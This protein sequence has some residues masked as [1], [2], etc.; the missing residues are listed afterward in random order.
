MNAAA[1][2]FAGEIRRMETEEVKR[3]NF[4]Q[5]LAYAVYETRTILADMRFAEV[6]EC[7]ESMPEGGNKKRAKNR[8]SPK[9]I[10]WGD[11]GTQSRPGVAKWRG[12]SNLD[13]ARLVRKH[14]SAVKRSNGLA[15]YAVRASQ[16]VGHTQAGID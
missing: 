8:C 14:K 10:R 2:K 12:E 5:M 3:L 11:A 4:G 13:H 16:A 1:I 6:Q 7:M 9:G 15:S